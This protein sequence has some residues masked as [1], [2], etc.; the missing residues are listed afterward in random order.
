MGWQ[1]DELRREPSCNK[2]YFPSTQLRDRFTVPLFTTD[3]KPNLLPLRFRRDDGSRLLYLSDSKPPQVPT[4][5]H[6]NYAY[7]RTISHSTIHL[8]SCHAPRSHARAETT[9]PVYTEHYMIFW[10]KTWPVRATRIS[11]TTLAWSSA[12]I[13]QTFHC[14]ILARTR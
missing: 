13:D 8:S 2:H 9:E 11:P 14:P 6:T 12:C 1:I 4:S 5:E 3:L 7:H 10:S